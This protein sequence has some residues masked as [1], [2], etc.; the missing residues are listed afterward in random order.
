M[1][2]TIA[3]REVTRLPNYQINSKLLDILSSHLQQTITITNKGDGCPITRIEPQGAKKGYLKILI[4]YHCQHAFESLQIGNTSLL[5]VAPSHVHFAKLALVDG[6]T[7]EHLFSHR[8]TD[9]L[10]EISSTKGLGPI[11]RQIA[12]HF[13][14]TLLSYIQ[15]GFE[16]FLIGIDH[17]AF[18]MALM[19]IARRLSDIVWMVTGFTIGHSITLSLVTL[20][21]ITPNISFIEAMIGF[22]IALVAIE[23]I[24][25]GQNRAHHFASLTAISLLFLALFT[26]FRQEQTAVNAPPVISLL[27]LALFS[28]CYLKLTNNIESSRKYR[29]V[30][31]T[32]F[33]LVHGFGF[34]NVLLEVGLPETSVLPALLGFNIG[35][36]L[37]QLVIVFA[38]AGCGLILIKWNRTSPYT[39]RVGKCGPMRT[40]CI[41]VYPE[42]LFLKP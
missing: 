23:N 7:R 3:S 5:A 1:V 2:F 25:S 26:Q 39:G 8:Q 18:L 37:G 40:G 20:G 33:G 22:T 41:L 32:A 24:S 11:E 12:S 19:L 28:W 16:H 35:V 36:E 14:N 10:L 15:F 13:T 17:L 21:I 27:G 9:L 38:L 42:K 31:T 34:A 29:P 30:I 6:T 4:N